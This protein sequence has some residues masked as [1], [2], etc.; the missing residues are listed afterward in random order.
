M[1]LVVSKTE[2]VKSPEFH[3]FY[4]SHHSEYRHDIP[5][6]NLELQDTLHNKPIRLFVNKYCPNW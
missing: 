1:T 5:L 3:A 6:I 4:Y 2:I